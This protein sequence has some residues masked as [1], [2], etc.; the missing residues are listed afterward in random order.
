M[1]AFMHVLLHLSP[2]EVIQRMKIRTIPGPI[3]REISVLSKGLELSFHDG[4]C[5]VLNKYEIISR[6]QL[7]NERY[8]SFRSVNTQ[9]KNSH[10]IL[11]L[12][13]KKN[14]PPITPF[15]VIAYHQ[16]HGKRLSFIGSISHFRLLP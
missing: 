10:L 2:K 3:K 7:F 16:F 14:G 6:K 4:K 11:D 12:Y 13:S 8:I 1:T 5:T 15:Q 9:D